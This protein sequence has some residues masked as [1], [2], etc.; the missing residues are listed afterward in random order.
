MADHDTDPDPLWLN[1]PIKRRL[2]RMG[3]Y[4]LLIGLAALLMGATSGSKYGALAGA[5]AMAFG[6]GMA[7]GRIVDL[8]WAP[9]KL[10]RRSS[11]ARMEGRHYSFAGQALHIHDDGRECWIAEAS[12]YKALALARDGSFK[13]RF[14][15]QWRESRELGLP[16]HGLW[17]RVSALHQFL[18]D[19]PERMDPRRVRLRTYLDRDVMQPAARRREQARL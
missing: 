4:A 2:F 15:N 1:S 3:F 11:L 16:G 8:L 18:A 19:A 17:V 12:V 14:A 6:I 7:G 13:G 10:L 5:V 9:F